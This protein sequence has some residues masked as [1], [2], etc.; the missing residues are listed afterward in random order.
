MDSSAR[1]THKPRWCAKQRAFAPGGPRAGRGARIVAL[2]LS[3][4][5]PTAFLIGS[6]SASPRASVHATETAARPADGVSWACDFEGTYC[7]MD[8]QSKIEPAR[9]STFVSVARH[10]KK[11]IMLT[12]LPG[13]D[14]VH[15]A[16]DWERDDLELPPSAKYCNEGQEE[17][18]AY[19]VRFPA[20]YVVPKGGGVVMDFHHDASGGQPNFTLMSRTAGLHL[21]GFYGDVKHPGE[22]RAELGPIRR[23]TW[24]DFVYHVKWSSKD[25]GF[26]SVWMDGRKVLV[27]HGPTLYHGISCYLKLANYHDPTGS[28]SSIIFDRVIRGTSARAVS[29]TRLE[30]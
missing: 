1:P 22:Y 10:G 23:N 5:F 20:D 16:G 6:A 27:H 25:D 2:L 11:A 14:Q 15:G 12:T 7:G 24:Y 18:W 28:P 29:R 9:R 19:S 17:W 26:I 3:A 13:D 4:F 21:H 30:G 8:E